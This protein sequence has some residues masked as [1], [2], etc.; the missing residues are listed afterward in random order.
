METHRDLERFLRL[1]WSLYADD[2][3]WIP[4]LLS[5]LRAR[6]SLKK[7]PYFEH[8]EVAYFLAERDG[9]VVGRISAQVCQ[10]AQKHQGPGTG[11]F[12]FFECEN[13][14]N[15]SNAL[16]DAACDW[17]QRRE[18]RRAIG[19][20]DLSIN[21]EI[22]ML[23]KGFERPPCVMM[24]HHHEYYQAMMESA[25]FEKEIDLY[26]YFHNIEQPFS[27]RIERLIERS[28]KTHNIDIR[29]VTKKN[30]DQEMRKVLELFKDAWSENWGYVPPTVAEVNHLIAQLRMLLDRGSVLIA[31]VDD[32]VAGVMVVLPNIYE[33]IDDLNGKLW[34]LGWVRLLWRM[35]YSKFN[36]VRV[37]LMGVRTKFQRS[38]IGAAIALSMIGICRD[39]LLPRGVKYCEMS[40]IL[41]S[42][43]PMRGIL[44][45]AGCQRDKTYRVYK[46]NL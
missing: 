6:T 17:L 30:F 4:P 36:T 46:K 42:N 27:D 10:L 32:E 7:N 26:A 34:P 22:G 43:A 13:Q 29:L 19:P 5:Q 20:L 12:G 44:E 45:S 9:E 1:P 38:R 23:V 28:R 24:G 2:P 3:A 37:P 18:M 39:Y 40:W 21:D 41:E 15:T 31:E 14:T 25:G 35:R 8:A 33:F 16:L 11:H